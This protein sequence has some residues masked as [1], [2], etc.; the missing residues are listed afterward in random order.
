VIGYIRNGYPTNVN[1]VLV[2]WEK[3]ASAPFYDAAS[4]NTKLVG[5]KVATLVNF[6]TANQ[7]TT[8]KLIHLG[9]HSLGTKICLPAPSLTSDL[10]DAQVYILCRCPCDGLR[11]AILQGDE[12]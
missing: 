2:Q 3:L 1:L 8:L 12:S 4:E 11:R 5:E 10:L 9:G 7:F 6:L